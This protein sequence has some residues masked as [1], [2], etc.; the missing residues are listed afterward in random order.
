MRTALIVTAL[1]SLASSGCYV[2]RTAGA[3]NAN[4]VLNGTVMVLGLAMMVDASQGE[5]SCSGD[6][7]C[8][9]GGLA[10]A[11]GG[12][13]GLG[14][15]AAGAIAMAITAIVPTKVPGADAADDGV[16]HVGRPTRA[17]H[18][19]AVGPIDATS[20]LSLP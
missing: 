9:G 5:S 15:V 17:L 8:V 2:G 11:G 10:D 1:V 20:E 14:L 13:L 7:S 12:M 3:K 16:I 6:A 18:S 4:Y 19:N